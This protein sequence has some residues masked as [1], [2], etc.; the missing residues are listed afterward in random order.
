MAEWLRVAQW[1]YF[2]SRI[3]TV[4]AGAEIAIAPPT[5]TPRMAAMRAYSICRWHRGSVDYP[6]AEAAQPTAP[7]ASDL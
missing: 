1:P 3:N 5:M 2:N 6:A 4:C 7:Q